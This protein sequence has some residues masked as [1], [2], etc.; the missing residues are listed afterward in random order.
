MR[1]VLVVVYSFTSTSRRMAE[2]LCSQQD[3]HLAE[4]AEVRPR[5]GAFGRL[6][7][8]LDSL[9]R[10]C[11]AIRYDGPL[12][13]DFDAVVLVSPIWGMRLAGPMRSFVARRRDHLPDVA[14][15]SLMGGSGATEAVAEI[16]RLIGRAPILSTTLSTQQV[17]DGSFATRLQAFGTALRG[18]NVPQAVVP[19]PSVTTIRSIIPASTP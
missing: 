19:R 8:V 2:L 6:R 18:V 9:F 1:K 10:R 11:P 14:V 4:I 7:C 13:K 12:P 17:Q 3:W 5:G 15:V 16:T